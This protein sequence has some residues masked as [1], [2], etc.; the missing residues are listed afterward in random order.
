MFRP[1]LKIKSKTQSMNLPFTQQKWGDI[2]SKIVERFKVP[3]EHVG[4]AYIREGG[5]S[6]TLTN[7]EELQD[8]YASLDQSCEEIKFVLQDRRTPDGESAFSERFR[9]LPPPTYLLNQ[10]KPQSLQFGQR[11][12]VDPVSSQRQSDQQITQSSA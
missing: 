5:G 8:F 2:A 3:V 11:R 12:P 10:P 7:E 6:V 4:I 1:R 9:S